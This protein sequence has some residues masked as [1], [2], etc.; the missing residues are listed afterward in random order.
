[1]SENL[2]DVLQMSE[3]LACR[4]RKKLDVLRFWHD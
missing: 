3:N 4:L 1:M 2:A